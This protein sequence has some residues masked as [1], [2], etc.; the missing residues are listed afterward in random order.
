MEVKEKITPLPVVP[1]N[2]V[3]VPGFT[4]EE[5]LTELVNDIHRQVVDARN[6]KEDSG[7]EGDASV[8]H[9]VRD[10]MSALDH[11]Y[12]LV[13]GASN[14][15]FGFTSKLDRDVVISDYLSDPGAWW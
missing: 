1:K 2:L 5:G 12:L 10:A 4:N 11:P 8:Y 14:V 3:Y 13:V 9:S 7:W 6:G 15:V